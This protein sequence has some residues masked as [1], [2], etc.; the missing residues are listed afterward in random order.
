MMALNPLLNELIEKSKNATAVENGFVLFC[1]FKQSRCIAELERLEAELIVASLKLA[2][3]DAKVAVQRL[4][5]EVEC[6]EAEALES[7]AA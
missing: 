4:N 1:R 2:I 6:A 5:D 3:I 7:E